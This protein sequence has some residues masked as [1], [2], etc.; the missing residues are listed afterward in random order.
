MTSFTAEIA[1][2]WWRASGART[3]RRLL[4][5]VAHVAETHGETDF[6]SHHEADALAA[7]K[8]WETF[9]D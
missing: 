6:I 4:D 5:L 3:K 7:I 2:E 9:T 8:D 1:L